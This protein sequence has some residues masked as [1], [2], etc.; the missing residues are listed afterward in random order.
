MNTGTGR[1]NSPC[2]NKYN[3]YSMKNRFTLLLMLFLGMRICPVMSYAQEANEDPADYRTACQAAIDSISL[4]GDNFTMRS[5]I[6]IARTSLNLCRTKDDMRRTMTALRAGVTGHLQ[7]VSTFT[8]GQSYTG[9]AGNHSFDTGDLALWYNVGFDLSKI[10]LSDI[11]A[12]I[13]NGNVS[14]LANAI[15]VNDWNEET[16]A[17]ENREPNAVQDGHG[18]YYL[19]SSQLIMQPII[20]LPAG[21]YSLSAKAACTPGLLRLNKVH[22]N[23]L[24]IPTNAAQEILGEIFSNGQWEELFTNFDLAKY[25][26]RF[27]QNGKLYTGSVSCKNLSTLSDGELRFVIDKGDIVI[28]GMNAGMV[29]FIGTEPFLADNLQ[30][31]GIRAADVIL[32]PAKADLGTALQGQE[33]VKA[34]CNIDSGATA[35]QPAFSYDRKLTEG[36]NQA[37]Q[38]AQDKYNKDGLA[39]LLTRNDLNNPDGIADALKNHY[40]PEIQTLTNTKETFDRQAFIAP[41]ANEAFNIIMKDDWISLLTPKW[42]GNAVTVQDDMTLRFS[43]K[44]GQSVFS[45]PFHF[46]K[47]SDEYTNQLYAYVDDNHNKYYLGEQDGNMALTTDPDEAVAITAIPSYTTE[48]EITLMAGSMYLG[49]SNSNNTLI[50]TGT[51]TLLRPTRTGLTVLPATGIAISATIPAGRDATTLMLPFDAELPEGISALTVT[52]INDELSYTE[53][54]AH[55]QLKANTPYIIKVTE[56]LSS[57]EEWRE[58]FSGI[59]HAILPSYSNGLLTGRHTPYTIHSSDEY[60]LTVDEDGFN[61]FRRAEEQSVESNECYLTYS[62]QEDVL[63]VSQTDAATGIDNNRGQVTAEETPCYD[64]CGRRISGIPGG[65]GKGI[66]IRGGRKA[67]Y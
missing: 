29:P 43:Q 33:P 8:D 17:I 19:R 39:D 60:K 24:V 48:G 49:T 66:Y 40:K 46:E 61:V 34:N 45:L 12:A 30:L 10:S 57:G 62:T 44:P 32:N 22:I 64:L 35:G 26:A 20:G 6:S 23:A 37:L 9:L 3:L 18:K 36:Y 53:V 14:G 31:T 63:F 55:A 58:T 7:T 59:P 41:A 15:T 38:N 54:E 52:G 16:H 27:L 1:R 13:G 5:M 28:I 65:R 2:L 42:T 67:C 11:T 47:A 56:P 21:I 50:K 51:G 4:I 25:M